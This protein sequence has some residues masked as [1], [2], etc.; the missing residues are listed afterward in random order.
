MAV[1]SA[2]AASPRDGTL[3]K[4]R[5]ASTGFWFMSPATLLVILFFFIPSVIIFDPFCVHGEPDV[6]AVRVDSKSRG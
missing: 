5:S 4:L 3:S 1:T 2:T 6:V